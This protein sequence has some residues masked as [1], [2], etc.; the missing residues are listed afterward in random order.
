[1]YGT[2]RPSTL[3]RKQLK[4]TFHRSL[5]IAV[6]HLLLALFLT[7]LL[8]GLIE[9]PLLGLWLGGMALLQLSWLGLMFAY[10]RSKWSSRAEPHWIRSHI[11]VTSLIALVWGAGAGVWLF[12]GGEPL[13]Q[14]LLVVSLVGV[15][16]SSLIVH[17]FSPRSSSLF[18]WL[19]LAPVALSC[20]LASTPV[21]LALGVLLL[22]YSF[23]LERVQQQFR[24]AAQSTL[25]LSHENSGLRREA[26]T[27]KDYFAQAQQL[28]NLGSW[29]L[30]LESG[31]L[32][33]SEGAFALFGLAPQSLTRQSV[34]KN[35]FWSDRE[36]FLRA[37]EQALA[38]HSRLSREFR[39][40]HPDGSLRVLR[41]TG[42]VQCDGN[43]RPVRMLGVMYDVTDLVTAEHQTRNAY[44]EF[45]RILTHMQDTYYRA[46]PAG[47]ITQVSRSM[48][49]LLGFRPEECAGMRIADLYAIPRHG[50]AF[51]ADLHSHGGSLHNYEIQM[52]H[53]NRRHVWVSVNAQ[54]IF[55]EHGKTVG[56]EGT[57]RDITELRQAQAALHQEKE[58]A[59]VTLQS[60]GDGVITTD[61][62]GKV[63]YLNPSAERLLGFSADSASGSHYRD[64]LKLVDEASGE[65]LE[66]LVRLCLS[67]E[68]G[69]AHTDEGLLIQPDGSRYHLKVTAAPMRD[70][71]GHVVG[72][73]LVLHDI[74]EVMGMARQLSYQASHDMLTGLYNRRVFEQR[75]E[76]AIRSAHSGNELHSMLYLD[77]DQFKVVNDT[78]GH[79][80]GD[81]LLQQVSSLMQSRV[82]ESDVLARLGGDEFGVLLEH[83]P[84]ARAVAIAESIRVAVRDFRFAWEDKAFEIGVSIGLVPIAADAGNLAHVLAAA[85]AACYLAKDRGRNR[86]HLYQPDD[87]AIVQRHGEMQWVHRLSSAF[88]NGRFQLYA[89]PI[90]HVAGDRVVSHYEVL[91]RMRDENGHIIPPGAFIPAA[92]RYNLMPTIDRWVIRNTLEML[93][94]AQG[95]LAF[96]PV[97][98]AINLS[99][100][101]FTDARFLEYVVDLFDET[102]IPC[103]SISFEVTETAAVANLSR[104]T[105]FISVLRGMGCSFA[106]DDF[107]AGLSSFGY[108][109]TLPVDYLK[110]DGAFVRDMVRD[111]V[112]RAMV[113]A[114]NEIGHIMG[115]KTIGE[116]A[117]DERVLEAL[118]SAGVDFAQGNSIAPPLPFSVVLENETRQHR[119]AAK[120][121]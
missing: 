31:V 51:L 69:D 61:D 116:Y 90:V 4:L 36:G 20:F 14:L 23:V 48:E 46:D 74:T 75:V 8:R 25:G 22:L 96:P 15:A 105:R 70:H 91:L 29:E 11:V 102:G 115:L 58:Q 28:A 19:V 121:G 108:L 77:L 76:E 34:V 10:H 100:Q 118:E 55:D 71:Y 39:V 24:L 33:W 6:S 113:E 7:F 53:R 64:V 54:F 49:K 112:D 9:P 120:T 18:I 81:E 98:C 68:S 16:A 79:N 95:E 107:G 66:D 86:L 119:R 26:Q 21:H 57:I 93:R 109:K 99:G 52:R 92:E 106:L 50:Q 85:D 13:V 104:A 1:M 114:I 89:Q 80:A 12:P 97:E 2:D 72:A 17:T 84:P 47:R 111:R 30:D 101:S 117:E 62:D 63:Q 32:T 3:L 78:C 87:N 59:L 42:E 67:L 65:S 110:I 5:P 41:D 83:C 88:D 45:N 40:N 94:E 82:R 44:R 27:Y 73:V 35:I 43:G 38:D 60:I 103:E 37:F 56:I